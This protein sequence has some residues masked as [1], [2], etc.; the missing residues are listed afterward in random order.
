MRSIPRTLLT[1]LLSV[2]LLC[3]GRPQR[4]SA[5]DAQVEPAV[6]L[7]VFTVAS[8]ERALTDIAWMFESAGRKDML[9]VI[10]G[11]LGQAGDLKGIDRTK[12]FG[13]AVFL[14]TDS[15]PPRPA[16]VFFAPIENLEEMLKTIA[17]APVTV[18]RDETAPLGDRFEIQSA[19]SNSRTFG[20]VRVIG[21]YAYAVPD[22]NI[23]ILDA[24]P[25]LERL[26]SQFASRYDAAVTV[27]VKA[28]PQGVRQVFLNFLRT[29]A[30]IDLQR[31]DD[32]DEA[33]YL[34]RRANGLNGLELIENVLLQGEDLTLGWNAEPE[35]HSGYLEG[36][37]NATPDSAFAKF[38]SETGGKTSMFTPLREA[39]RPLTVNISWVMNQREQKAL[40]G[41]LQAV[42]VK[43]SE[44][45][46]NMGQPGGPIEQMHN[47]LQATVDGGHFDLF[48]QFAAADVQKFVFLGGLRVAGAQAFGQALQQ[49]LQ[50]LILKIQETSA[51]NAALAANAPQI[52][53]NFET[54]Q[55]VA[56]HKIS[57]REIGR[58]EQRLYG[59]VPDGYIG[60]SSRAVWFAVG[61]EDAL[62]T[63]KTS[64]DTLLTAPPATPAAGGNVPVSV[65]VRVAPWLELPLPEFPAE[66]G[67][68]ATDGG[69]S[70]RRRQRLQQSAQDRREL[71]QEAFSPS[72]SMRIEGRPMES[73]FRMRIHLDEGFIKLLGL[74][75]A[76]QYDRSQL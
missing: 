13:Q 26:V 72:D 10:G 67:A 19:E 53:P 43:L 64:L 57:P 39:D 75:I 38:L 44:E 24:L 29:Q 11:L 27:Q 59:G 56:F 47:S 34:V 49:F 2:C 50:G 22:N 62:P 76:R 8:I 45:L 6:P 15:L 61:R 4:A 60:V 70:S 35:K 23:D 3:G 5:D 32:E 18:R 71:A 46:P 25:D 12:P 51:T 40:A 69:R 16:V 66:E 17:R 58:E 74:A 63:L 21:R 52:I 14:Q 55:D 28:V 73:G 41:L 1:G 54:H 65:T 68:A 33:A 36:T 31:R 9:D 42:K 37:L 7:V 30:E 48:V 20:W